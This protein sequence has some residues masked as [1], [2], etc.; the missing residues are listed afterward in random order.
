MKQMFYKKLSS[1][2]LYSYSIEYLLWYCW[3]EADAAEVDSSQKAETNE[4]A[5]A[6]LGLC[7]KHKP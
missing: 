1:N 3:W 5:I 4:I 6:E 2:C 7:Y